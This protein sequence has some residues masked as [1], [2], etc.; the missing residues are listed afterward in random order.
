VIQ[1]YFFLGYGNIAP[2]T[3]AGRIFCIVFALIG[4][5]LTLTVIADWGR[6]FA[7]CVSILFK[8]LRFLQSLSKAKIGEK[9][10]ANDNFHF[11]SGICPDNLADKKWLYAILAIVFLGIYL[12]AGSALMLLWETDWTFFDGYYFCFIT[13]TTIGFGDLVPSKIN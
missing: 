10:R 11:F 13:M 1:A 7:T 2:V 3:T 6:L 12:A 8:K 5:P 4:I 9:R